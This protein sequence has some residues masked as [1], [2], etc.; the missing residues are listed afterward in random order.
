MF[1]LQLLLLP[2]GMDNILMPSEEVRQA[3]YTMSLTEP[4]PQE[5]GRRKWRRGELQFEAYMRHLDNAVSQ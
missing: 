4:Q 2:L 1:C 3:M 5:E